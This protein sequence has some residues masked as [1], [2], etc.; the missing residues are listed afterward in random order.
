MTCSTRR[1]RASRLLLFDRITQWPGYAF[2]DLGKIEAPTLILCGDRD[3]LCSVEEAVTALPG[4]AQR[5]ARDPARHRAPHHPRVR[6]KRSLR[7]GSATSARCHSRSASLPVTQAAQ[8]L[9]AIHR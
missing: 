9:K 7:S 1:L 4:A 2:D 8:P 3:D 5:R 6:A